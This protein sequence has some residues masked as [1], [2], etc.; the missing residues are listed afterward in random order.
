M[1]LTYLVRKI[2]IGNLMVTLKSSRAILSSTKSM[3]SELLPSPISKICN[4]KISIKSKQNLTNKTKKKIKVKE[5]STTHTINTELVTESSLIT[6]PDKFKILRKDLK[7]KLHLI[8]AI[9]SLTVSVSE[10]S[11]RDGVTTFSDHLK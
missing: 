3:T 6:G 11:E 4:S 5:Q 9:V 2:S 7:P 8:N 10:T 1:L